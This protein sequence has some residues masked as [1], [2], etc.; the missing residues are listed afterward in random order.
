MLERT[1]AEKI[2]KMRELVSGFGD[3][4]ITSFSYISTGKHL[5]LNLAD[6]LPARIICSALSI[7]WSEILGDF[8]N[9][10]ENFSTATKDTYLLNF[11]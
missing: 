6:K 9:E 10:S 3:M 5:L 7:Q 2:W 1:I 4:T 11:K 8:N